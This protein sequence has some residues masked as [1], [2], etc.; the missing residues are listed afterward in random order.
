ML[1]GATVKAIFSSSY[2]SSSY[3]AFAASVCRGL[4]TTLAANKCIEIVIGGIVIAVVVTFIHQS[5]SS[6]DSNL[7]FA[8]TI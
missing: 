2:C 7:N 4:D 1:W 8:L 3:T 6:S 5:G